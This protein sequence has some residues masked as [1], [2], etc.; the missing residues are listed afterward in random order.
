MEAAL[1]DLPDPLVPA[2]RTFYFKPMKWLGGKHDGHVLAPMKKYLAVRKAQ[3]R[4]VDEMLVHFQCL[5]TFG[6]LESV[7]ERKVSEKLL[8]S[9]DSEGNMVMTDENMLILLLLWW[10]HVQQLSQRY[11]DRYRRWAERVEEDL[12]SLETLIYRLASF[13][14][15]RAEEVAPYFIGMASVA[16][17]VASFRGALFA[18]GMSA[19]P[20]KPGHSFP[21]SSFFPH[22]KDAVCSKGWCPLAI[23]RFLE[24]SIILLEYAG[25]CKPPIHHGADCT[26]DACTRNTIDISTYTRKHVI[27]TCACAHT[28]PPI[29]DVYDLLQGGGIPVVLRMPNG[30]LCVS[31]ASETPYIA[32]SHVWVDGLGSTSEV[33]LPT[34][35]IERIAELVHTLLPGGAFWIDSLCIPE[36][37]ELRKEAIRRMTLTYANARAVLVIDAGIRSHSLSS[38]LEDT[39]LAILT[40]GW[41]QRLWTLQEGLLAK[42]L[43]FELSDG[44][45]PLDNLFPDAVVQWCNPVLS[46]SLSELVRF[47]RRH[48]PSL[49]SIP[50]ARIEFTDLVRFL[51]GRWTS[52]PE[53]ETIAVCGLLN[54]DPIEFFDVQ[55]SERL[56]TLLL[57]LRH[58]PGD[59]IFMDCPKMEDEFG[60]RWAPKSL[61]RSDSRVGHECRAVCTADGLE[62]EY[63]C[64]RLAQA[65]RVS[66]GVSVK[67]FVKLTPKDQG[68]TTSQVVNATIEKPARSYTFNTV[69]FEKYPE[70]GLAWVK[71][72]L[73]LLNVNDSDTVL[74]LRGCEYR[75]RTMFFRSTERVMRKCV[76][77]D[78]SS[79]VVVEATL[80]TLQVLVK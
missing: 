55:P 75:E 76:A 52:R 78:S 64:A 59:I 11:P 62:A 27:G 49:S 70:T 12:T 38:P 10:R 39:A 3:L 47:T 31:D 34:C 40:S 80:E 1:L 54:V 7:F 69:L 72:V 74:G 30:T 33:G 67:L 5:F 63:C 18:H 32:I 71:G 28:K 23:K 79:A 8:L 48:N 6:L 43:I 42:K 29:S 46:H 26:E 50:N 77:E 35:Q 20:K 61:M 14:T 60:F 58:L 44:F 13:C 45:A 17:T 68:G 24:S 22:I 9:V 66:A 36:V 53:D 16:V 2:N 65:V 57:Q 41:M 4:T 25:T 73:G 56:K 37:R 51:V 15:S 21:V 19:V